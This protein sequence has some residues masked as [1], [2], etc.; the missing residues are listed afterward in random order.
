V[1]KRQ[2]TILGIVLREVERKIEQASEA[3][4]LTRSGLREWMQRAQRIRSQQPKDK[5]KLY[6]RIPANVTDD[7]GPS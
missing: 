6:V 4:A 1:L 3:T 7:S 2:R 5:N